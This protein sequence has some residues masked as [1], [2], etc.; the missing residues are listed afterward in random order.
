MMKHKRV[1]AG[2]AL[3]AAIGAGLGCGAAAASTPQLVY[4]CQQV[5]CQNG[6]ELEVFD[7][8]G[9]PGFTVGEYGGVGV[10]GDN[11]TLSGKTRTEGFH[12][13]VILSEQSPAGYDRL[14]RLPASCTPPSVWVEPGG[15][16]KCVAGR[17]VLR[18]RI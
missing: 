8:Y 17:W 14:F 16:W 13:F 2:L 5:P 15:I 9:N 18:L 10:L 4:I 7:G 3:L 12:H 1:L 6:Q 11:L